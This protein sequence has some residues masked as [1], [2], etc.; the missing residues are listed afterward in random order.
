[1]PAKLARRVRLPP[2]DTRP[3]E[4]PADALSVGIAAQTATVLNT[5]KINEPIAGLPALTEHRDDLVRTRTQII[6]RL[7]TLLA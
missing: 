5:V 7:H 6:N 3:Q 4:H 1:M 2:P